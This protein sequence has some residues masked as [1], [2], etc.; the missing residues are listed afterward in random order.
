MVGGDGGAGPAGGGP[1]ADGITVF[2]TTLCADTRR[3]R[4]LLD[5]LGL[6]YAFVDVELGE[7]A[8]AWVRAQNGGDRSAPTI[9]LGQRGPI[10]TEPSDAELAEALRRAGLVGAA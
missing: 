1:A 9:V 5:R 7:E 4:A 10:L 6:P 8:A 2:G 3:S